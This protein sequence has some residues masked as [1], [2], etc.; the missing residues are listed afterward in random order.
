MQFLAEVAEGLV[1]VAGRQEVVD[2]KVAENNWPGAGTGRQVRLKNV[3]PLGH[4]GSTPSPAT[5][6]LIFGVD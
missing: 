4:E 6:Q 1:L 2:A 3:C 5:L